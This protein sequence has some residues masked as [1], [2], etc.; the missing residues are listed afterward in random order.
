M[1]N[2]DYQ[3]VAEAFGFRDGAEVR[4]FEAWQ[5]HKAP[6]VVAHALFSPHPLPSPERDEAIA[7]TG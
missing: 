5:Q 6:R 4:E 1:R 3:A 2:A 7:G